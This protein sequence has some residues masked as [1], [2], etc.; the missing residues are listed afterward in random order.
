V[1]LAERADVES[2]L[3][4][5]SRLAALAVL[6]LGG[7]VLI[8]WLFEVEFLRRPAPGLVAMKFNTA[9]GFLAT[10]AALLALRA[11]PLGSRRRV[12][13]LA[14]AALVATLGALTLLEYLAGVDL[15]V[16]QLLWMDEPHPLATAYLGRMA[17]GTA[18]SF[19]LLGVSLLLLERWSSASLWAAAAA[20]V[21]ATLALVG[22]AYGVSALYGLGAY[23]SMALHTAAGLWLGSLAI[24]AAPP[25][26]GFPR[27]FVSRT[28]GGRMARWLLP[29]IPVIIFLL[30][31]AGVAGARAGWYDDRFGIA[32]TALLG[33]LTSALIIAWQARA[34]HRVDLERE[35]GAAEIVALNAGLERRVDERTQELQQ[36]LAQ[37]KQLQGLLPICSWCKRIRDSEDRWHSL[38]D[39]ISDR[40][41]ARFSHGVCPECLAK[42]MAGLRPDEPVPDPG[43]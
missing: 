13:G 24:L 10:G 22:Y 40:T 3:A 8:G 18:V 33:M 17:P 38:E 6:L 20:H 1:T 21:L 2:Y 41:D 31:W 7:A 16:D 30:G 19:L 25:A 23:T 27:V 5:G 12:L 42:E 39:Y 36:A 29:A 26:R 4:W 32:L 11:A 43:R 14:L 9:G 35:R 37:V 28:A 15:G 34:L